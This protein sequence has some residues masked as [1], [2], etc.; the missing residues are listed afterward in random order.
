MANSKTNKILTEIFCILNSYYSKTHLIKALNSLDSS[1]PN[2]GILSQ[3]SK[4]KG[5]REL[6][7]PEN[8]L[9]TCSAENFP[10]KHADFGNQPKT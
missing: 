9:K 8:D 6:F 3:N 10:P 1:R 2:G 7:L 5:F 4:N